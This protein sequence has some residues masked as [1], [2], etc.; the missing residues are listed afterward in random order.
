M[1]SDSGG[2]NSPGAPWRSAY[3]SQH[4]KHER[5]RRHCN[6]VLLLDN[7]FTYRKAVSLPYVSKSG[8]GGKADQGFK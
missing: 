7:W 2:K 1:M 3:D 8:I 4:S 6:G 5:L